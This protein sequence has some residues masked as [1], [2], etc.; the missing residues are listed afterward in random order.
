MLSYK[1]IIH[2]GKAHM[3]ELL[4]LVFLSIHKNEL[5]SS[6][7]RVHPE[8]AAIMVKENKISPDI[9]YIDCGM[10]LD[11]E[12][13]LY[14]H[15]QSGDLDCSALLMFDLFFP[16]LKESKLHKYLSTVSKVDTTGPNS[17][18]DFNIKS[19]S[20]RYF[21]FS[22]KIILKE[23]EKDP[24]NIVSIFKSGIKDMLDFEKK[25]VLAEI[26]IKKEEHTSI[27]SISGLNV[28]KYT[29]PPPIELSSAVKS[30]DSDII[31]NNDIDVIYSFD[32]SDTKVR[33][34]FRTLK[35]DK[36]VNFNRAAVSELKFC[37]KSGFLLK[38]IPSNNEEW[39]SI[40]K[41]ASLL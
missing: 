38:F 18:E 17:L 24:I 6:V 12:K 20:I 5:P 13:N 10:K 41:E 14:D 21:G 29:T 28:L 40:I 34:L 25:C 27:A 2:D 8:D 39:E 9:Y 16:D 22:Q 3:D 23:F 36:R 31:D 11:P 4:G 32:K 19:E 15:H 35:G 30:V 26:W 7:E 1:V 33:T 37:H